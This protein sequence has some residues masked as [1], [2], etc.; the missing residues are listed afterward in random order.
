MG[1]PAG[2]AYLF[3]GVAVLVTSPLK[4]QGKPLFLVL[5]ERS[6]AA[7]FCIAFLLEGISLVDSCSRC[8]LRV[9]WW[10]GWLGVDG[11][12]FGVGEEVLLCQ[13]HLGLT[14]PWSRF[15]SSIRSRVSRVCSSLDHLVPV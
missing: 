6:M 4:L 8:S 9:G 3:G 5:P 14:I 10:C 12:V 7:H 13:R 15:V 11:G 2:V 1:T